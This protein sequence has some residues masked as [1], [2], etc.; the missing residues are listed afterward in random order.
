MLTEPKPFEQAV[1]AIR[2]R[3]RL[4]T[5]LGSRD[6]SRLGP[7]IRSRALVLARVTEAEV[8]DHFDRGIQKL[9]AGVSS[10]P[11][12]YTNPATIRA[13]AKQL[14]AEIDYRP[15]PERVGTISD[16]RT[17]A[18][19][20]LIIETESKLA[21]GRGQYAQAMDPDSL[22]L[23]PCAELIRVES[24]ETPRGYVRRKGELIEVEREYWKKRWLANGGQVFEDRMIAR[25]DD[26]VWIQINRFGLPHPPFDFRSGMGTR[27]IRRSEAVRLGVIQK[28]EVVTQAFRESPEALESVPAPSI[29]TKFLEALKAIGFGLRDGLLSIF[30]G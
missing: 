30:R 9:V 21:Q 26:P 18:R 16:L 4:P 1:A 22:A 8:L 27:L 29:G 13:Q 12:Q 6:L 3:R 19:L 28:G 23:F 15:D 7:A 5:L 2:G 20:N 24:R 17:D 14:L 11:G 10:G 25:L